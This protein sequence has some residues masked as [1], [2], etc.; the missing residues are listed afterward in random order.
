MYQKYSVEFAKAETCQVE[1][2]QETNK[3]DISC[4]SSDV[5]KAAISG[6]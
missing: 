4:K 5:K 1:Q 3:S 6:G 2:K